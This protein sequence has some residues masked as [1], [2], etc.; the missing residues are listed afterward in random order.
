MKQ[1]ELRLA[2]VC[3]G[4]VSLA[5]Y[6][7]GVCKEVLKLVR[8]SRAYHAE[9][10]PMR[11]VERAY[12]KDAERNGDRLDSELTYFELLRQIGHELDLRVIVD[13]I[14]GASA[15]GINGVLLGRALAH[16]FAFDP[17]RELWL[18]NAD[19]GELIAP[20]NRARAWSKYLV[21]PLMWSVARKRIERLSPDQETR[22]K[23]SLLVRSR[24]F[25]PPFS[26][27]TMC[28][29]VLEAMRAMDVPMTVKGSLMPR[30]LRLDLFVTATDFHGYEQSI[31]LHDPV[32][33]TELEH[34]H[35]FRFRYRRSPDGRILT[36]FDADHAPGL[37]FAARATSSFPGAFPPAQLIELDRV[38]EEIGMDWPSRAFFVAENMAPQQARGLDV[39][40]VSFIDG[41]VLNNKPFAE[42]IASIETKPAYR[43]VDRRLVFID[44][45]PASEERARIRR[46]PGFLATLKGALSDIPRAEPVRDELEQIEERNR[47]VRRLKSVLAAERPA[48]EALVRRLSGL[49]T[50]AEVD[51]KRVRKW[52]RS[53]HE[54]AEIQAGFT[55]VG[56][57]RLKIE[58]VLTN[59]RS[60]VDEIIEA[61]G[62][63]ANTRQLDARLERWARQ[64]GVL[65]GSPREQASKS[66]A[67]RQ[68]WM[69]FLLR[70]DVDYRI[71]RLRFVIRELN[72]LYGRRS[73]EPDYNDT[74]SQLDLVKS[75]LYDLLERLR[76]FEG[77]AC[78]PPETRQQV[79]RLFLPEAVADSVELN[80]AM[81]A[82]AGCFDLETLVD[83]CDAL[84]ESPAFQALPAA[85]RDRL[86]VTYVGF[87]FWD[88][89][90]FAMTDWRDA[91]ELEEIRVD[92]ISPADAQALH[93]NG[94]ADI[95]KGVALGHFAAFFSRRHREHDYLW[96][97]LHAA[98]RLIDI[99]TDCARLE[100]ADGRVNPVALKRQAFASIIEAEAD[101]LHLSDELLRSLRQRL[102]TLQ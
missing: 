38:V 55:Y 23:L 69:D 17:L 22:D 41:S 51:T 33:V 75:E 101:A 5:V 56:Y 36:D 82:I 21:D 57:V 87:A 96:G 60:L 67:R 19:V 29:F 28:R 45:D 10:D 27:D 81:L 47:E 46:Q 48:I 11:R 68:Q 61:S 3:F 25:R 39:D 100:F 44:P 63:L 16:D 79:R 77:A 24:W 93:S 80:E 97:R 65:P 83:E 89:L 42:A 74:A 54:S 6:M 73:D 40:R 94:V 37:A 30:G 102:E 71:R 9:P 43:Q 1:K 26:G 64:Q 4:G 84:F 99:V 86:A 49:T 90:A 78:L 31:A 95:L 32:S 52:R 58:G 15:G 92:R 66:D 72:T 12:D 35:I 7:H 8:A 2:L 14:A 20:D 85:H 13:A 76:E 34:R 50:L 18:E 91:T 59:L 53:A 62:D 70:Y 98:E 88:V